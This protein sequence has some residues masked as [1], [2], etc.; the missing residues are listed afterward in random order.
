MRSRISSLENW[1]TRVYLWLNKK[2]LDNRQLTYWWIV[3]GWILVGLTLMVSIIGIIAAVLA[4]NPVYVVLLLLPVILAITC[5]K[6]DKRDGYVEA[7]HANRV[8]RYCERLAKYYNGESI[9][10]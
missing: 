10:K 5:Y 3:F 1:R 6:S 2:T 9:N 7:I 4:Q 8:M